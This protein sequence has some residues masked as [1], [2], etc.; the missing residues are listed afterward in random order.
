MEPL[1]P[2]GNDEI[3]EVGFEF[4][5]AWR[6]GNCGQLMYNT[7]K[8]GY[9]APG[10][11]VGMDI[12]PYGDAMRACSLCTQMYTNVL[13]STYFKKHHKDWMQEQ[14]SKEKLKTGRNYLD[15]KD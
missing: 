3:E 6:C 12:K 4:L 9:P 5:D 11:P 8:D 1:E 15:R 14:D 13:K 2:F 10:A 7:S